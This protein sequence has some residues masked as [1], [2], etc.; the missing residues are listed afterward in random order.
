MQAQKPANGIMQ[1]GS[2]PDAE[3]YHIECDCTSSDHAIRMWIE[4]DSDADTQDVQVGFYVDTWT[5]FW[6]SKFSRIRTAWKI[7]RAHV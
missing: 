4:V 1:T 3:S 2:Y 6:E 5:P 7:G